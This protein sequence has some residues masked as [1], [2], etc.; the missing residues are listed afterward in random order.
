MPDTANRIWFI[1]GLV[2]LVLLG[3]AGIASGLLHYLSQWMDDTTGLIMADR[4][5]WG[6]WVLAA[7]GV[8][9]TRVT[10]MGWSFRTYFRWEGE[11]EPPPEGPRPA[12]APWYKSPSLSFG[13]TVALVAL[14]GAAA[15]SS[16]VLWVVGAAVGSDIFWLMI[17]IIWGSWWVICIILVLIRVS[18]FGVYRKAAEEQT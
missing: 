10:I 17:K 5:I 2:V 16:V 13:F 4:I 9:L 11:G 8:L 6:T 15:V 12:R 18:I 1:I 7:A 14:T 3:A